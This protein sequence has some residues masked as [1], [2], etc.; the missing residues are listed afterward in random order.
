MDLEMHQ[1]SKSLEF[2]MPPQSM[3]GFL[4]IHGL[5]LTQSHPVVRQICHGIK[6]EAL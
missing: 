3:K 4:F 5:T 2:I 6:A 1:A